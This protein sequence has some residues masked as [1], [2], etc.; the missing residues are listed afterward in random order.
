MTADEEAKTLAKLVHTLADAKGDVRSA[1]NAELEKAQEQL[2][3]LEARLGEVRA[4]EANL[5]GQDINEADVARALEEFDAIWEVL[6]TPERERV[7]QLLIEGVSHNRE[8]EELKIE[9]SPIGIA[10]LQKE[11]DGKATP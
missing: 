7:L 6:L 9:L 4:E 11:L 3:S 5:V 8:T 2:R 10:T 1:V